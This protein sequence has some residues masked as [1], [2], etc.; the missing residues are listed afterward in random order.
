[1]TIRADKIGFLR[2]LGVFSLAG[3]FAF[4]IFYGGNHAS[5][6]IIPDKTLGESS[7]TISPNINIKGLPADRIDGGA[8]RDTNLF[9]SFQE[10]NLGESGRVY[11]ANPPGITNIVARVTGNNI[12]QILGTLGVDGAANLFLLNRNGI[13]FGQNARLD[14]AGSFVASTA[15]NIIFADGTRLDTT[16][17]AITPLLTITAPI[18]LQ[19]GDSPG[20][21]L[22]QGNGRGIR[23]QES[24]VIDTNEALRV[25]MN[26]TLALVGGDVTFEGGTLKT[27]GGR[28]EVGSVRGGTVSLNPVTNGFSLGYEGITNFQ[29]I[30]LLKAT[31]IDASG[32]S[33]G[34]IQIRGK[35]VTLQGGSQIETTSLTTSPGGKLTVTASELVE[36]S[37]TTADNPQDNR[38][39]PSSFATDNRA[40]GNIPGELTINTQRLIVRDG[41][42]ISASSVNG[43]GGNITVNASDSVE[44]IGTFSASGGL[45]SSGLSVQTRGRGNAGKLTINTQNLTISDGAELSASTF[46]A[47]SGGEIEINA[48]DGVQLIGRSRNSELR[49]RIVA[50]VGA[51]FR[52]ISRSGES[53]VPTGKGGN[54]NIATRQLSVTNGAAITVTSRSESPSAQGAGELNITARNILLNNKGEISAAS[55][56]GQGGDIS[57]QLQDLLLLRNESRIFTDAGNSRFG[58]DGGNII[59]DSPFI[60]AVPQENSDITANAYTG[61]GGRVDIATSG[62]FGIFPQQ[63]LTPLSDI[64]ASSEFGIQGFVTINT[65][66]VDPSRGLVQLPA[67]LVDASQKIVQSCSAKGKTVGRFIATGRG[68]LPASPLEPLRGRAIVTNWVNLPVARTNKIAQQIP[69]PQ[70]IVEAQGWIESDRGDIILVAQV[71][72]TNYSSPSPMLCDK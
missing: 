40:T 21:I 14:I 28:I 10:F 15:Q 5:A 59:I 45:R 31:T 34:E 48:L 65:P 49:S 57:L 64:T 53:V 52:E 70:P 63:S 58:G 30:Q 29:D 1:M 3:V 4:A 22:V 12:S 6:E 20:K 43:V 41:G 62:I 54:L 25:P 23:N 56:S 13:I 7:S 51:N 67:D 24:P 47:G 35:R 26:Q 50:E 71:P 60:A 2:F 55:F 37:G 27:D 8:I 9:H 38:R 69:E 18:G 44:L 39:S 46:G 33:G 32:L 68:G 17:S 66:D 19:L 16:A 11:F 72:Q 61:K 42:R 36:L